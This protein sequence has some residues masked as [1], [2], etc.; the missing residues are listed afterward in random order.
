[1]RVA[2]VH[3]A[4]CKKKCNWHVSTW[5]SGTKP[6][7]MGIGKRWNEARKSKFF[8]YLFGQKAIGCWAA[9]FTTRA[10]DPC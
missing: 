2:A 6:T 1:M 5:E 8:A 10:W 9:S 3:A 4:F 7:R